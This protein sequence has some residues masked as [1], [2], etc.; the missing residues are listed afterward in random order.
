MANLRGRIQTLKDFEKKLFEKVFSSK[1]AQD[2]VKKKILPIVTETINEAIADSQHHFKPHEVGGPTLV[3]QL[4][5]G[6]GGSPDREKLEKA[7]EILQFVGNLGSSVSKLNLSLAKGS[8]FAKF[9]FKINKE[10]F[11]DHFRT[12]YISLT[13]DQAIE[14]P[15]MKNFLLGIPTI[16]G[17]TFIPKNSKRYKPGSSRTGLGHM[18]KTKVPSRQFELVGYG[19]DRA[20]GA[21]IENATKRLNSPQF[22][23]KIQ[24]AIASSLK[25]RR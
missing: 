15:W 13:H 20:F 9:E 12:N 16:D 5:V 3:G 17:Y 1:E 8:R 24:E 2:A 6:A 10:K 22:A 25:R 11:Y 21:I 7:W 23:K 19:E 14:I 18:G 4:G